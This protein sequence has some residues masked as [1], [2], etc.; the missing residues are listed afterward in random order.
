[1]DKQ[2]VLITGAS[3]GIGRA[4]ALEF[5]AEGYYVL[6][7]F[8]SGELAARKTLSLIHEK[9]GEGELLP[10]DVTNEE[11][12]SNA[13]FNWQKVN[14]GKA[15]SVLVNNAGIR[16]D[17][18]LLFQTYDDWSSV[19]STNLDGFFHVTRAILKD[20]IHKKYGRI[21]NISSLSGIK[22]MPGQVNYA[23][24]KGGLIAATKSLALE[25]ARKNITVNA[26][27]PGFIKTDMTTD[28]NETELQ[29]L[30]PVQRFG[31]VE[32]VSSLVVFLAGKSAGYI[33]G[34]VVSVNGG[35][36]T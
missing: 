5:A 36:Y 9:E 32:E 23:A 7:N 4:I 12:V 29:K 26:V 33:T 6:I 18:L 30:I 20:M 27:A 15:I 13:I 8:R 34:E 11:E 3:R 16:K 24:S 17:N 1:M 28:L 19:I 2:I 21:I 14:P 22:G 31:E 10:F 25:V 35:L